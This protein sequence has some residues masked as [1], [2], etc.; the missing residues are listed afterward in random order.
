MRLARAARWVWHDRSA[1]AAALRALLLPAAGLYRAVVI[2][3][4]GAYDAGL[5][6]AS[7]LPLPAI[8]VGNLSVGG[9][10]KTPLAAWL[11]AEL[12]RRGVRPGIVLR[13]YGADEVVEYASAVPGA[14]VEASADRRTAA[15]TAAARGA[16]ALVLDDCLQRRDVRPDAMLAVVAAESWRGNPWPLP[17]GP[18]RE[19]AGALG[20]ADIVVV[21]CKTASAHAAGA[22][23]AAL[24]P[25]T[26]RGAGSGAVAELRLRGLRPLDGGGPGPL[27][28]LAPPPASALVGWSRIALIHDVKDR[29]FEPGV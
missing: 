20:R 7:A 16:R 27:E 29:P 9:T 26:R 10:G 24:A 19:G 13:G 17:A 21:T 14:A 2:A 18:W 3:R 8:G 23:A 28:A 6:R 22:L 11:A 15:A 5:L 12:L 25:R 4:N 1:G